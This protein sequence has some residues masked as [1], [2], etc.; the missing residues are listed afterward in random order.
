MNR[1]TVGGLLSSGAVKPA[2]V[3][4]AVEAYLSR[5]EPGL[6]KMSCEYELDLASA[7]AAHPFTVRLLANRK[8]G[9]AAR[10]AAVRTAIILARPEKRVD[11]P[12]L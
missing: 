10:R 5:S 3:S 12:S 9:V 1:P 4:A 8:C 6:F 7:V 2:E 11:A